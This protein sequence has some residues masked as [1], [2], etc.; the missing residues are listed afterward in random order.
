MPKNINAKKT[1]QIGSTSSVK[2]RQTKDHSNEESN[3]YRYN[4]GP[5]KARSATQTLDKVRKQ[6]NTPER[7]F[8]KLLHNKIV[9]IISD[10]IGTTFARPSGLLFGGIFSLAGS[11]ALL[12]ICRFYG[13]EYSYSLGL[14][15]LAGGFIAGLLIEIIYRLFTKAP[16]E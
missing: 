7:Q 13:Y 6:L 10:I 14:A 9:E 5:Y 12:I 8:S 2:H 15:C 1:D 4:K 3:S 16:G 11:L